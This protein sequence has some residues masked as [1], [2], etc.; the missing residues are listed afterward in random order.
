MS[1][2]STKVR[3][4]GFRFPTCVPSWVPDHGPRLP[5]WTPTRHGGAW[6]S[7]CISAPGRRGEAVQTAGGCPGGRT[8]DAPARGVAKPGGGAS[9]GFRKDPRRR[10]RSA[11]PGGLLGPSPTHLRPEPKAGGGDES[12]AQPFPAAPDGERQQPLTSLA[13]RLGDPLP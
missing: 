2:G 9:A 3:T 12:R 5:G 13:T 8:E 4:P 11:L 1:W 10:E 7:G 6:G